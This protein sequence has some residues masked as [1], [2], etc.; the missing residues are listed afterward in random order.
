MFES[1]VIRRIF[2]L[3]KEELTLVWTNFHLMRNFSNCTL[4]KKYYINVWRSR[5][6]LEKLIFT[7]STYIEPF[8][9]PKYLL[10]C[11]QEPATCLY[12][13]ADESSP[14]LPTIFP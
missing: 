8:M 7:Q 9:E 10:P 12:P 5:V 4:H 3:K 13:E 2:G 1:R 14:Q 11:S 6:L